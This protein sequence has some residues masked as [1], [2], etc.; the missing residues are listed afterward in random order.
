MLGPLL[1]HGHL[2]APIAKC[3]RPAEGEA[4]GVPALRVP[5]T[6]TGDLPR[7]AALQPEV[8]LPAEADHLGAVGHTARASC[9]RHEVYTVLLLH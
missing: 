4:P 6:G 9:K 3:D 1:L 7:H 5:V 2:L 8:L